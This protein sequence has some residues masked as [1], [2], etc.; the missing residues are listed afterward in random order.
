MRGRLPRSQHAGRRVPVR[1]RTGCAE[2]GCTSM[3]ARGVRDKGRWRGRPGCVRVA[4]QQLHLRGTH[5]PGGCAGLWG[6]VTTRTERQ[7]SRRAGL[8]GRAGKGQGW[9][10]AGRAQEQRAPIMHSCTP[11][12]WSL[13]HSFSNSMRSWVGAL[14]RSSSVSNRGTC[15]RSCV[16]A[17]ASR[18]APA[19][20]RQQS[21]ARTRLNSDHQCA[22]LKQASS[23]SARRG[24]APST[25]HAQ[26]L[27]HAALALQQHHRQHVG[28]G[29]G[30][31]DH[32]RAQ[33]VGG[34]LS[35]HPAGRWEGGG[36][37]GENGS[38]GQVGALSRGH[39]CHVRPPG[40][41]A[42]RPQAP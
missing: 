36:A 22:A 21:H 25:H 16:Q 10:R 6:L 34:Q 12:M 39:A 15:A 3:C 28:R 20:H 5:A 13:Y 17:G 9:R 30:H 19:T 8:Q 31:A 29:L 18:R 41:P 4:L 7:G 33:R 32:V 23:P 27:S 35:Q 26:D 2:A 42:S 1:G 40:G 11:L 38:I 24:T 37:Q 14:L